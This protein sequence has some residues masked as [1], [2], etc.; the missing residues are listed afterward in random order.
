VLVDVEKLRE[1][2]WAASSQKNDGGFACTCPV[3][4]GWLADE[5]FQDC[6][7]GNILKMA[8]EGGENA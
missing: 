3:C 4:G 7:L 5:H 8:K 2:E 1:I 6:W